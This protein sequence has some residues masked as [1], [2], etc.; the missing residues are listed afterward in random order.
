MAASLDTVK[1]IVYENLSISPAT[2][3]TL[4]TDNKRFKA[5]YINDAIASSDLR[6]VNLLRK[7]KQDFLLISGLSTS[8]SALA[9]GAAIP[10]N[11]LVVS[12]V[13]ENKRSV[14]I[15]FHKYRLLS[16]YTWD[17][18]VNKAYHAFQDGKIY[19][20]GS[21][22]ATVE[23]IHFSHAATLSSLYSPDGFENAV[24][25][26][27]TAQLLM[28]RLDRPEESQFYEKQAYSFLQEYGIPES[29]LMETTN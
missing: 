10:D 6:V 21:G 22:N 8:S 28:K 17:T 11:W 24:A 23:Y 27:A 20:V 29:P 9:S 13:V 5:T 15:P 26:L 19:F 14:E 18:S 16:K 25:S 1:R 7:A 4:D 2:Y 12:V 3:G